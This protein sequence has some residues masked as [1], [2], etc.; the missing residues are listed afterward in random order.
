M[1]LEYRN[2]TKE[3]GRTYSDLVVID[4]R[5]LVLSGLVSLDPQTKKAAD[6][7]IAFQTK[8]V[9]EEL[10]EILEENGSDMDHVIRIEVVLKDFS[11]RD[12]MNAEY[13]KHFRPDRLPARLC[14]GDVSLADGLKVEMMATAAIK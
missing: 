2:L 8:R 5:Y 4:G 3:P 12:E 9:L 14:F 1:K 7:S 13:V 10:K 11:E 6:G